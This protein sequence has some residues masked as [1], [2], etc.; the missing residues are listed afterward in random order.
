MLVTYPKINHDFEKMQTYLNFIFFKVW[1]KAS[2]QNQYDIDLF[3]DC[4]ELFE[5]VDHF[6]QLDLVNKPK[7]SATFF[8]SGLVE[9][10]NEFSNLSVTDIKKLKRWYR[11]NHKYEYSCS[12]RVGFT[13]SRYED[14]ETIS[15][16]LAEKLK[17]FFTGLYNHNFL[18]LKIISKNVG[19]LNDY[20]KEL[21]TEYKLDIC[22]FCGLYP[23]DGKYALTRDAF[24]HYLPKSKYPFISLSV[25]NLAP[26]C[27]KCNSGNKGD[28]DPLSIDGNS[29]KAFYPFALNNPNIE[30]E[31]DFSG[32]DYQNYSINDVVV[33]AINPEN[34]QEITTWFDLFG[35]KSRYEAHL[36]SES[37]GKVWA[38]KLFNWLSRNKGRDATDYI[39]ELLEDISGNIIQDHYF[40]KSPFLQA[41][42]SEEIFTPMN[43][44]S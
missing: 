22:P 16:P 12:Q 29:R 8:L 9:I 4:D 6:Y 17:E 30:L 25:K 40:L 18:E 33:K 44:D 3:K 11:S 10:Y 34:L 41:C 36:C 20:Y 27:Y 13:P 7:K 42:I 19:C 39:N 1:C 21:V 32:V 35:L 38:N 43:K 5:I 14:I 2:P 28:K 15:F 23:L 31:I 37:F 26:A 24:D